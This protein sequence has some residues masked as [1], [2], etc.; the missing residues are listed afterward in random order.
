MDWGT[1]MSFSITGQTNKVVNQCFSI[2]RY[3]RLSRCQ[4]KFHSPLMFLSKKITLTKCNVSL[5]TTYMV[6]E[7][8]GD[9]GII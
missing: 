6:I 1:E 9:C 2:N 3:W 4:E 8:G 7:D 5:G